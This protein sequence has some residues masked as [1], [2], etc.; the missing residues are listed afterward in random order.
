MSRKACFLIV[1]VLLAAAAPASA[2]P[3]E[4]PASPAAIRAYH[5][6]GRWDRDIQAVTDGAKRRLKKRTASG[7]APRRPAI[8]LDIDDTSLDN[9]PCIAAADFAESALAVC[10]VAF[11][12]P[13]V[14][15]TRAVFRLARRLRVAVF[16]ITGRPEALRDGTLRDLRDSGYTGKFTLVMRPND[17]DRPSAVPYKSGARRRIERRGFTIL[18][19]VGDQRSDLAGGHAERRYLI[20]NPMY[21]TP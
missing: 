20:P 7:R 13:A 21:L 14:R 15:Q 3:P 2:A 12:T 10:V 17:Y 1:T 6:S 16:F 8:V 5:D 4:Y 18:A 19:N 11:D 9:Y